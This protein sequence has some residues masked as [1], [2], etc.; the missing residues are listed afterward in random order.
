VTDVRETDPMQ[1]LLAPPPDPVPAWVR[2]LALL[3]ALYVAGAHVALAED[4]Y[5]H[6]SHYVGASFVAAALVLTIGASL[7][8]AGRRW[9]R[10]LAALAWTV[11]ALVAALL[12][13][14]FLLSRTTGLPS[15]HRGDW[16]AVEVVALLMEAGYV[17]LTVRALGALRTGAPRPDR[18]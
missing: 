15:Y 18:P 9:G 12:F 16:D 2:R 17:V 14:T 11:D 8:A 6:T 13:V 5:E 3:C 1:P 7:A 4:R 10:S